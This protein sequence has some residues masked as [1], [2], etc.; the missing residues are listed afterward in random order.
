MG[1]RS[2][3]LRRESFGWFRDL[4]ALICTSYYFWYVASASPASSSCVLT[5]DPLT[6]QNLL[7]HYFRWNTSDVLYIPLDNMSL[8]LFAEESQLERRNTL[9]SLLQ[10][11]THMSIQA[12]HLIKPALLSSPPTLKFFRIQTP[13]CCLPRR[14]KLVRSRVVVAEGHDDAV[15][16]SDASS[17]E[18]TKSKQT[19]YG[20]LPWV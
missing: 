18:L 20:D 12:N 5:A 16:K 8:S 19:L 7:I 17:V 10:L 11:T 6:R 3:Q 14:E 9:K 1:R 15:L 4:S 13:P 2:S